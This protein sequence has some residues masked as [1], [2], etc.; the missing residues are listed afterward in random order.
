MDF[1]NLL[2]VAMKIFACYSM[3]RIALVALLLVLSAAYTTKK[4]K[5]KQQTKS[6]VTTLTFNGGAT[7]TTLH[8]AELAT[9][10]P[11][12]AK[13]GYKGNTPLSF[14]PVAAVQ[15]YQQMLY[16]NL[17]A[18]HQQQQQ[19]TDDEELVSLST[20]LVS[21]LVSLA[22]GFGLGYGT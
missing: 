7:V 14:A 3:L 2:A 15:Q 4:P 11:S 20:A 8:S 13:D 19:N 22:L 6:K 18:V 9:L 16:A 21:C 5:Y 10:P 12:T 1:C 17:A